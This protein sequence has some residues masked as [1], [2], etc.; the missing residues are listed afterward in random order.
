MAGKGKRED[1]NGE[2]A[3][4][5]SSFL[6]SRFLFLPSYNLRECPDRALPLFFRTSRMFPTGFA[7]RLREGGGSLTSAFARL[8]QTQLLR[9]LL[10]LAVSRCFGLSY[11]ST[12]V[13]FHCLLS[14]P[15]LTLLGTTAGSVGHRQNVHIRV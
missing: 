14:L 2:S 6:L 4:D 11:P 5:I 10:R 9:V 1:E 13:R 7:S 12:L 3:Y 8:H 15:F